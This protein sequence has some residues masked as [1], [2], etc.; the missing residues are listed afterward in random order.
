MARI[1]ISYSRADEQFIIEMVPLLKSVFPEHIFWYDDHITGGE[2]WWK[3]IL[4]EIAACDLFIYL[5]S[6][7]SLESTYCQAEFKEAIRLRKQA[8]PVI[9]RPKTQI[10]RAPDRLEREIKRLNWV[11]MSKGF[12][13]YHSYTKLQASVKQRLTFVPTQTPLPIDPIPIEEPPVPDKK[14][15]TPWYQQP[16]G[17]IFIGIIVT[18]I[19]GLILLAITNIFEDEKEPSTNQTPTIIN[20]ITPIITLVT[21]TPTI[22]TMPP[23]TLEELTVVPV[24]GELATGTYLVGTLLSLYGRG[25]CPGGQV[26]ASKFSINGE[27]FGEDASMREQAE[28]WVVI[29]GETEICFEITYGDWAVSPLDNCITVTGL[30]LT[31]TLTAIKPTDAFTPTPTLLPEFVA[32]LSVTS[33]NTRFGPYQGNLTHNDDNSI[34]QFDS[35]AYEQNFVAEARFFNPYNVSE[36]GWDFGFVFRRTDSNRF[37]GL[38]VTSRGNWTLSLWDESGTHRIA[39][40]NVY[41]LD[42]SENGYNKLTLIVIDN[43]GIF[44]LND[45][46]VSFLDLSTKVTFGDIRIG[47]GFLS[48]NEIKGKSTHYED[49][50]VWELPD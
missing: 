41:T 36:G 3:R 42:T 9:V 18:V 12:K 21:T 44:F 31:P 37:Y 39:N 11:D 13:D 26:R 10:E 1:F 25:N 40:G 46:Q 14:I 7:D 49:F 48:G 45:Q 29:E 23:C 35:A 6:N 24:S 4:A 27:G 38:S 28:T 47:A 5:L 15:I 17:Q 19:G 20:T 50:R 32:A 34:K 16:L 8:L 22:P 30:P 43:T 33:S 2:D